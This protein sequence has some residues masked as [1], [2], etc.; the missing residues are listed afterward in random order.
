MDE[1]YDCEK[2][3]G[4]SLVREAYDWVES[5]VMAFTVMI[6]ILTFVGRMVSVEGISMENTLHENDRLISSNLLYDPD[7]GDIVVIIF[8][9]DTD[10]PLVKRVIATEGQV[11]DIDFE[12][13]IV[14]V[15][16]KTLDEPYIAESTHL[17][18][19]LLFPLLVPEGHVFVMGDNRNHSWDSRDSEIGMI[20]ERNLLGRV[21]YRVMPFDKMGLPDKE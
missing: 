3:E 21:V 10:R 18:Y 19:D 9:E 1:L 13:G 11:V 5:A 8:P 20:D 6:L 16:G 7:Y 14:S 12:A 15:D 2:V 4:F 17:Q